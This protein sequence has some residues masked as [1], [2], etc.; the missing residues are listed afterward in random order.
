MR[1]LL[2]AVSLF[3]CLGAQAQDDSGA[4]HLLIPG[5]YESEVPTH[6]G[7]GWFALVPVSGVWRL[8]PA[9][10]RSVPALSFYDNP[11]D[12]KPEDGGALKISSNREGTIAL[13]RFDGIRGGKVDTPN[14]EFSVKN[15]W[16]ETRNN[17][18]PLKIGFKGI[19]Y[20]LETSDSSVY[21]K[22]GSQTTSLKFGE[23]D[24]HFES[25][26]WAGDLDR[27][28]KLDLLIRFYRSGYVICLYL[29][30]NASESELVKKMGCHTTHDGC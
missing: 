20:H 29:S 26:V 2:I 1:K 5:V 17:K 30:G 27:D 18:L 3:L 13:V 9:I 14:M 10:V 16:A 19:E 23:G 25:L 11:E 4:W 6:P 22:S 7:T 8:E 24:E 12:T 15:P 21:L 28:G